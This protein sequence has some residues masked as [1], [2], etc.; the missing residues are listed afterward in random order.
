MKL[1]R[2]SE[3][4]KTPWKN[5]QGLTRQ[6]AIFP[7]QD[8]F[9]WRLSVAEIKGP[10]HFSNYK[11]YKRLLVPWKGNGFILNGKKIKPFEIY[12]FDGE[13]E[14]YCEI[15]SKMVL[16]LGLIYKADQISVVSKIHTGIIDM[17]C[18]D[19]SEIFIFCFKGTLESETGKTLLEG[20]ALHIQES[21]SVRLQA[22]SKVMA[23]SLEIKYLK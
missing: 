13:E 21:E 10:N 1:I 4:Q 12:Q 5:G 9:L 23:I 6:I 22:K 16:D 3:I 7:Q 18:E 20:D 2:S 17:Q 11:G 15:E 14:I 8:D 19:K